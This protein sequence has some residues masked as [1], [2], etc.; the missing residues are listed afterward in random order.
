MKLIEKDA[1][2]FLQQAEIA[3]PEGRFFSLDEIKNSA[4][5]SSC[6]LKA[7][8][9]SGRRG[10]RGLVRIVRTQVEYAA[11]VQA[12]IE[13]LGTIPCAGILR[14]PLVDHAEEWLVGVDIDTVQGQIR[15]S[16]SSAGGARVQQ[17]ETF[18]L[19]DANECD[20]LPLPDVIKQC[21]AKLFSQMRDQDALSIE[22][23]PLAIL[24]S[25]EAMAL[26]AKMEVDDTA[27]GR[28]SE[29]VSLARLSPFDRPLTEREEA[30]AA[31]VERAGHRGTLGRYIELDGDIAL[32]LSGGGASLVA[33][34][35]LAAAGGRAANYVEMSGNPDPESVLAAARIACSKPGIR[36]IWM[37][38]SHA[39]FT[40]IE[41]TVSAVLHAIEELGLRVPIVIRRD[42]PHASEARVFAEQWSKRTGVP[43][44]F[45]DA[46]M[47]LLESAQALIKLV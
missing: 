20:R 4:W 33:L 22:I 41:A 37:A 28:H 21:A 29:W 44:H 6:V 35:A 27:W 1:K 25:G 46:T 34:D 3:I 43:L 19:K 32:I 8:V 12:L 16:V 31:L 40:D 14:E 36:A 10:L 15:L 38:G 45:F 2:S 5:D 30:Y 18:L 13:A 24:S 42:G 26:D 47:S 39:N 23:N 11:Q 7:Q 17:A 9:L